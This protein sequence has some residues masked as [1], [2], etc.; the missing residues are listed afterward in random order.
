MLVLE[1]TSAGSIV[2]IEIRFLNFTKNYLYNNKYNNINKLKS[3][4]T[5]SLIAE[6]RN[7][8]IVCMPLTFVI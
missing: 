6:K 7:I 8:K 5:L 2:F 4:R 3:Y 1:G